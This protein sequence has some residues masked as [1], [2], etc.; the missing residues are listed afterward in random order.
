MTK[1]DFKKEL[2]PL[3]SAPAGKPVPVEVPT[4]AYLM[5]DGAGDPNTAPA[6]QQAIETLFP[7]AYALKFMAKKGALGIDY[8]VMPLEGLWWADDMASFNPDDKA[9]W[10]W[11]LMIMQPDFIT[12]AMVDEALQ[13][14]RSKQ[15]PV[16]LPKLRFE[17]LTEGKVAQIKHVGPFSTEG[18]TVEALHAFIA[19]EGLTRRGK[20]HEI[21]LSDMRRAAPE[22]WQTLIRQPVA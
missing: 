19:A 7:V 21:Y 18:P 15:N 17:T 2:K 13:Q 5:I 3:Y 8:G 6:F 20:H 16:A 4:L 9:G 1:R 22:K 12:A 11:T 14:V 10:Q